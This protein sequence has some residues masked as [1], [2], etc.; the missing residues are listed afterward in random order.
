MG[1]GMKSTR[2]DRPPTLP[3]LEAVSGGSLAEALQ[4]RGVFDL[5]ALRNVC[6]QSTDAVAYLHARAPHRPPGP[7]TRCLAVVW[8]SICHPIRHEASSIACA[9]IPAWG[10]FKLKSKERQKN[11]YVNKCNNNNNSNNN[12]GSCVYSGWFWKVLAR[13]P[14]SLKLHQATTASQSARQFLLAFACSFVAFLCQGTFV[15]SA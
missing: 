6:R 2:T 7:Q 14:L 1:E 4:R 9:C 10:P 12:N 5:D 15:Q 13:R 3:M 11:L 8:V